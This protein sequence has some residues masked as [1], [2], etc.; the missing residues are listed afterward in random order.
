MSLRAIVVSDGLKGRVDPHMNGEV[1]VITRLSMASGGPYRGAGEDWQDGAPAGC[2]DADGGRDVGGTVAAHLASEAGLGL[3]SRASGGASFVEV[4]R[5]L[6]GT[7]G[8][9]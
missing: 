8:G 3:D 7:D 9:V 6:R 1:G 4:P 5:L 2:E